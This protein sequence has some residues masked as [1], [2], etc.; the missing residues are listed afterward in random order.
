MKPKLKG[1]IPG[2]WHYQ[3]DAKGNC[4]HQEE[5]EQ[6]QGP[7]TH[8]FQYGRD[9]TSHTH[10]NPDDVTNKRPMLDIE[11]Q[12]LGV[13]PAGSRSLLDAVFPCY[14]TIPLFGDRRMFIL[15]YCTLKVHSC[16]YYECL[17]VK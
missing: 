4:M 6:E 16:F 3:E 17:Q 8:R 2:Y 9:V 1:E 15:R 12:G 14:I 11:L 10:W 5:P 7:C 13:C